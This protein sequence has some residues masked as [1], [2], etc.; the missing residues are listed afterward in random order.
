MSTQFDPEVMEAARM[1]TFRQPIRLQPPMLSF[2]RLK[3]DDHTIFLYSLPPHT[4]LD[5]MYASAYDSARFNGPRRTAPF[6]ELHLLSDPSM[7]DT[8]DWAENIRWAKE[9]FTY[10]GS[11]WIEYDYYL[12]CITAHRREIN[13]VSED[14]IR[15]GMV[16]Y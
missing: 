8:S 5:D 10:F 12:E 6:R 3:I 13:W 7:H 15:A 2:N 16:G 4:N 1:F 14:M 11:V 9:Q